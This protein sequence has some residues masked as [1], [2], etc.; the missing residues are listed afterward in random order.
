M[1]VT[2]PR[3]GTSGH[4]NRVAATAGRMR[5]EERTGDSFRKQEHT[6]APGH[7]CFT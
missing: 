1:N 6:Q 7:R 4:R 2:M 5:S 3:G